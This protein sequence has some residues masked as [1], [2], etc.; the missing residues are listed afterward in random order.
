MKT[1]FLLATLVWSFTLQAQPEE[2]HKSIYFGGGR[3][4]IDEWQA[5]ELSDWLDSI[6]NLLEKYEIQLISHTDPIGGKEFNQWLS[7]MRSQ[8]IFDLLISKDI[9]ERLIS[10][11]DWGLENPVYSNSSHRGMRL[12]RRVDVV[13]HPV[14]F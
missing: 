9:P 10:I 1:T 2:L 3:Y 11:K 13:L 8:V 6:P 12:N 14:V 7:K 5:K 4:E